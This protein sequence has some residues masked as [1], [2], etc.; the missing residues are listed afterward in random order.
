MLRVRRA[1]LRLSAFAL[2]GTLANYLALRF[3]SITQETLGPLTFPWTLLCGTGAGAVCWL[4]S[5]V[6]H[7]LCKPHCLA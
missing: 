5:E 2:A 4:G 7:A 3:F 1:A 6:G